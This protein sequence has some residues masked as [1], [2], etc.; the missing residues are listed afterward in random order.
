MQR[1]DIL[2]CMCDEDA[3]GRQGDVIM[4]KPIHYLAGYCDAFALAA[5]GLK[6]GLPLRGA[7]G[8]LPFPREDF[9]G[10]VNEAAS[11]A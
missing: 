6:G 9:P 5:A 11:F 1:S 8:C 10:A 2:G 7:P 3:H 4:S